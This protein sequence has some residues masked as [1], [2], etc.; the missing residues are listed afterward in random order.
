MSAACSI[1][2]C[3]CLQL[4]AAGSDNI[5]RVWSTRDWSL[6]NLLRGHSES[7]TVLSAHPQD[8]RLLLS[9]GHDGLSILWDLETGAELRR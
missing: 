4:L 3:S 7:V 6:R 5:I 2:C 8:P 9:A 1:L